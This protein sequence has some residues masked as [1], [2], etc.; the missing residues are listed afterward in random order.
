MI[1][2]VATVTTPA[3]TRRSFLQEFSPCPPWLLM[4]V[5][6]RTRERPTE[7]LDVE[8]EPPFSIRRRVLDAVDDENIHRA[9]GRFQFQPELFLHRC[10]D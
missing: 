2:G 5:S 1:T 7:F 9:S 6:I 10:E 4:I 8:I 3:T